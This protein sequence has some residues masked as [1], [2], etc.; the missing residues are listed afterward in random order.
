MDAAVAAGIDAKH[1]NEDQIAPFCRWIDDYSRQIGLFGGIDVNVLCLKK[2]AEVFD[3]VLEKGREYRA[4]TRGYALGSGC[5]PVF[6][7][8]CP[9]FSRHA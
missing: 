7:A 4:A 8:E 5:N 9:A 6:Q 3:Y 1:S 2:P